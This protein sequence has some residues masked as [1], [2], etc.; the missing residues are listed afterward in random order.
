M[1]WAFSTG[2]VYVSAKGF[3]EHSC[4]WLHVMMIKHKVY[5][6]YNLPTAYLAL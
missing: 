1:A 2:S 4:I 3:S 5:C 6:V